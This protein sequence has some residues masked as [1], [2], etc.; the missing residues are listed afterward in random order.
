M[1]TFDENKG[2]EYGLT[3]FSS[4]P[5]SILKHFY[6]VVF[7]EKKIPWPF[8]SIAKSV[9]GSCGRTPQSK[10]QSSVWISF[11]L[12]QNHFLLLSSKLA[13]TKKLNGLAICGWNDGEFSDNNGKLS[14][15][16]KWLFPE[17]KMGYQRR[18]DSFSMAPYGM[19]HTVFEKRIGA[20]KSVD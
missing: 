19:V 8:N 17:S 6:N 10:T 5:I 11:P 1:L 15:V 9:A 20:E 4:M 7:H 3:L 13:P 14:G 16:M 18:L 2:S 12:L